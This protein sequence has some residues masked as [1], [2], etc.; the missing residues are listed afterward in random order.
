MGDAACQTMLKH[1]F[2]L[3]PI[4]FWLAK[5]PSYRKECLLAY[6]F[7]SKEEVATLLMDTEIPLSFHFAYVLCVC[8]RWRKSTIKLSAR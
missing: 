3:R 8:A 1:P 6:N 2:N 7:Y 4:E 5:T